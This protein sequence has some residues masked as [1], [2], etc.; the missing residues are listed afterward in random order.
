MSAMVNLEVPWINVMSK[1]DLVLPNPEEPAAGG[2]NGLR[3]RRNIARY[4]AFF[5]IP[6]W[7]NFTR[8]IATRALSDVLLFFHIRIMAITCSLSSHS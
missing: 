4:I 5:V 3:T 2:R 6:A 7:Y 1:M 8:A